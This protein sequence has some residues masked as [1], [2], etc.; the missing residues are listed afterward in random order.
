MDTSVQGQAEAAQG[1]MLAKVGFVAGQIVQEFA[2]D[3]DVDEDLRLA[4][5]GVVG[6]PLEDE[7]Y[8]DG[9]D[10]VL[11]WFRADDGDLVD[12]LVDALTNLVDRGFVVLCTPRTGRDGHVEPSDIEDA[13]VTAGLHPA[14]V[15]NVSRTWTVARLVAPRSARR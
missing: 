8:H 4:I 9:A 5:E 13:A 3:D 14:G 10:A 7:S 12:T 1:T 11:V 6:S 15:A 2:W